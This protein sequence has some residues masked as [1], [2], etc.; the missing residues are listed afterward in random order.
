MPANKGLVTEEEAKKLV[1]W[2]ISLKNQQPS[3]GAKQ[4]PTTGTKQTETKKEEKQ[5]GTKK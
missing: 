5:K 3:A 2:I 4:Q 1:T